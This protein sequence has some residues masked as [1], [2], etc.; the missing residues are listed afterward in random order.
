MVEALDV[1]SYRALFPIAERYAFL[2]HASVAPLSSRAS[3]AVR[4][5]LDQLATEPVDH[6]RE[7]MEALTERLKTR[8]AA[9]IG[10]ARPDEIVPM[11][12]TAA[13]INTAA[14]SLPLRTGDN[15]LV[16]DGDYP[17]NI[18]P[19]LNLAPRGILTKWVPQRAGGLDLDLLEA[20][21]DSH[22][23]VVA[24]SSAMF[25]TGYRNDLASVGELCR[26]RGIYFVVDGI[27]SLGALEL[28]VQACGIDFLACGSHKWLLG[29]PGSGFLYCRHEL[30]DELQLGAYVGAFSTVDSWSFL[31]YN[32]T[33]QPSS[34]RFSLGTP[35][36]LGMAALEAS[37]G[38][39]LEVGVDTIQARILT[40][41]DTLVGDLER[42]GYHVLLNRAP[43]H[44][45]GIVVVD[46]PDPQASYER[47][48]AAGVVTS[49][50]GAGLRLSPHFY[51]S[52]D[53]V[54]RVGEVLGER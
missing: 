3:E 48:L 53:D 35:N 41:T 42:R 16:L 11:A 37:V 49:V 51:N 12:G 24:L 20:R 9:L 23:R 32:F 29:S 5:W 34:E 15:V 52:E 39:L 26:R 10:A 33:L 44:R 17:A 14:N 27:Q 28:D 21:I 46:V 2:N 13:G 6:L 40:L 45:S 1:G 25:A 30:L 50:R 8:L 4:S 54:L 47:L 7:D 43:E 18:Y 19:W 31:D 22:T 36:I 38:L